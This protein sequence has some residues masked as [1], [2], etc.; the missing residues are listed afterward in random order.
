VAQLVVQRRTQF[1][2]LEQQSDYAFDFIGEAASYNSCS[3]S[4]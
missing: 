2:A 4:G 3:A 1:G